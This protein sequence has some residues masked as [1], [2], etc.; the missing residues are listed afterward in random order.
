MIQTF[1][2][3]LLSLR[4]CRGDADMDGG[5]PEVSGLAICR[6]GARGIL[7]AGRPAPSQA[8]GFRGLQTKK[9]ARLSLGISALTQIKALFA[10][11]GGPGRWTVALGQC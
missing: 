4:R 10:S 11:F 7:T 5:D 2:V 8:T 6:W 3:W 9:L 1:H